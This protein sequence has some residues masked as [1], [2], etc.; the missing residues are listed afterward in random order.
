MTASCS[1]L[2]SIDKAIG[3]FNNKVSYYDKVTGKR[4]LSLETEGEEIR[5]AKKIA[6]Q[7]LKKASQ[8]KKKIDTQTQHYNRV[9]SIFKKLIKVCHR[10]E[11]PWEVHVIED[12][13][14]NA[15]TVGGGIIFVNTGLLEGDLSV[16]SDDE[17]A[18]VL[19]HEIAHVT[20]RHISESKTKLGIGKLVD[21]SL[22]SD[23]YSASFS[24][25]QEAEADKISVVYSALAGY[26]PEA[27]SVIWNRM[28]AEKGPRDILYTHPLNEDRIKNI[29][30]H[31]QLAQQY[32]IPNTIN[33]STKNILTDNSVFSSHNP[34]KKL[35][36]GEG[37]GIL[38]LLE[39]LLNTYI[40]VKDAKLEKRKRNND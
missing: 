38:S 11:L 30:L 21:K 27:A 2:Q 19:A 20:T 34:L 29:H 1:T 26:N 13:E 31:G 24:T 15:Y 23:V 3:D 6:K 16:Q 28:G 17:L 37:G 22:R 12:N 25:L 32:Y 35:K 7:I 10:Q 39:A 5:R 9:N 36:P 4:E 8:D 14:W 33:P 40:E 18:A